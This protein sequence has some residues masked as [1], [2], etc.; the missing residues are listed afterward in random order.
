M[1]LDRLN[2]FFQIFIKVLLVLFQIMK[3][4]LDF[5]TSYKFFLIQS[6]HKQI[7]LSSFL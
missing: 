6:A 4:F 5:Q 2:Y 1:K 7:S 3:A